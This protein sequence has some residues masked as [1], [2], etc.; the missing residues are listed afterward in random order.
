M[1]VISRR[2]LI[3]AGG[4]AAGVAALTGP[5]PAAV[6][7]AALYTPPSVR[8]RVDLNA[9][10]RFLRSDASGAQATSFDDSSWSAV[11]VPHTW[12]A[13]DGQDGGGNYYRG[14]GWY[15]RHYTP[16]SNLAG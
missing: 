14:T 2:T 16:P 6:V 12:N 3:Q 5:K 9:G 15:R 10:W 7:P 4:L 1:A 8:Q 13:L 11:S